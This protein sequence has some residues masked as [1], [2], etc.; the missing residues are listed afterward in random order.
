MKIVTFQIMQSIFLMIKG[1]KREIPV[2]QSEG[3]KK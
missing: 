2:K 3:E 1:F